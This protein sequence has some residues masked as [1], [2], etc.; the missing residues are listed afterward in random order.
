MDRH[1]IQR[2]MKPILAIKDRAL[3][4]YNLPFVQQSVA[5]AVRG[6]TDE[7]NSDPAKSG[8]AQHPDD[9]DLYL[10]G[11]YDD[12]VGKLWAHDELELIVRGKDLVRAKE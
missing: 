9:Y 2:I 11:Y 7:V 3:D 6:F 5:Q 1:D 8:I 10:I 4:V 12:V